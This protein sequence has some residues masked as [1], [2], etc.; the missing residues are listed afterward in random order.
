MEYRF[1]MSTSFQEQ[2]EALKEKEKEILMKTQKKLKEM[3][4]Y[5]MRKP[6]MKWEFSGVRRIKMSRVRVIYRICKEC[7]TNKFDEKFPERCKD[8]EREDDVI[9]L[10]DFDMSR[11]DKTYRNAD[12][13]DKTKFNDSAD[14]L[15]I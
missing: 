11:D 15:D 14:T 13:L 12:K 5:E 7:R 3:V 1:K 2:M 8:C 6:M 9:K 10:I 4:E